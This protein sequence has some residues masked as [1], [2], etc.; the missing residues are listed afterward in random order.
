MRG[1]DRWSRRGSRASR[2]FRRRWIRSPSI[3]IPGFRFFYLNFII[4]IP[5]MCFHG[6]GGR[7]LKKSRFPGFFLASI[8]YPSIIIDLY[9]SPLV[10]GDSKFKP[11][12]LACYLSQSAGYLPFPTPVRVQSTVFLPVPPGMGIPL[13]NK[14]QLQSDK[15]AFL[16][17]F[18]SV[19]HVP[20]QL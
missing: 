12:P 9:N 11:S 19:P 18:L 1:T 14:L 3:G 6:F 10:H 17:E 7:Y 5:F 2:P 20:I 4:L 8:T 13:P 15:R 16:K